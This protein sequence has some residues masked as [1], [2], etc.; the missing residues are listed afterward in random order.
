MDLKKSDF[1]LYTKWAQRWHLL[2]KNVLFRKFQSYKKFTIKRKKIE[3]SANLS[4]STDDLNGVVGLKSRFLQA[5][6]NRYNF[7]NIAGLS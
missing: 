1:S 3:K 5:N 2:Y 4:L 7:G 6:E